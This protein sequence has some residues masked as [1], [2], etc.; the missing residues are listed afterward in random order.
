VTLSNG[1]IR[2]AFILKSRRDYFQFRELNKNE[3]GSGAKFVA[4][5]HLYLPWISNFGNLP[6]R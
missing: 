2:K 5:A 6:H 1:I 4:K 3:V